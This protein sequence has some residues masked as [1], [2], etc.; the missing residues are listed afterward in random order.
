[1][2]IEWV[3]DLWMSQESYSYSLNY[4]NNEGDEEEGTDGRAVKE[5]AA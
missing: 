5:R 2:E 4:G 1:M 3:G